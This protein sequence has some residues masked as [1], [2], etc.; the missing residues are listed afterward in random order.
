[1]TDD[2]EE[3]TKE[4]LVELLDLMGYDELALVDPLLQAR[5]RGI[6]GGSHA[7]GIRAVAGSGARL[8]RRCRLRIR[9]DGRGRLL[10]GGLRRGGLRALGCH[11]G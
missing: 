3:I 7:L 1:M 11:E 4:D 9:P 8:L 6:R 5:D 10:R 2:R